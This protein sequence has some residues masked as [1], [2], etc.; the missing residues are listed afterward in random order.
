MSVGRLHSAD[1]VRSKERRVNTRLASPPPPLPLPPPPPLPSPSRSRH[2][3]VRPVIA[4]ALPQLVLD[5]PN[6]A[7]S[8]RVHWPPTSSLLCSRR[9]RQRRALTTVQR[10]RCAWVPARH[11]QGRDSCTPAT[12]Q[13]LAQAP[14]PSVDR[15]C[16]N[17]I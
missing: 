11:G 3:E 5:S 6:C 7:T 12:R 4:E 10:R 14:A 9:G 2:S 16:G 13:V 1:T 17:A 15:E 8:C